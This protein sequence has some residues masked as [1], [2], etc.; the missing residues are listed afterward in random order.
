MSA[1]QSQDEPCRI[2]EETIDEVIEINTAADTYYRI[3]TSPEA[4]SFLPDYKYGHFILRLNNCEKLANFL[5]I[6]KKDREYDVDVQEAVPDIINHIVAFNDD[7]DASIYPFTKWDIDSLLF[8][9]GVAI[10]R[11]DDASANTGADDNP[12]ENMN[13]YSLKKY[14]YH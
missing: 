5:E 10:D 3:R 2:D 12:I 8:T 6:A 7:L 4:K 11:A 9:L 1:P 13:S 14:S